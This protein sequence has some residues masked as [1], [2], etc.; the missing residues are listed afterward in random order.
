MHIRMLACRVCF[1][2]FSLLSTGAYRENRRK[3]K[4]CG[5]VIVVVVVV[6]VMIL[7]FPLRF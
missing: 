5:N 7:I 1:R 6:V 4:N 2:Y 3:E